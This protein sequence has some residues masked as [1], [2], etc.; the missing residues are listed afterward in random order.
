MTYTL[1]QGYA[2]DIPGDG[3]EMIDSTDIS[4]HATPEEAV[5]A[6]NAYI[7]ANPMA[8]WVFLLIRNSECNEENFLD[9]YLRIGYD[10]SNGKIR[11]TVKG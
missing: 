1:T 8:D 2:G 6:W 11:A 9:E 3:Y 10:F 7:D 4:T 5:D